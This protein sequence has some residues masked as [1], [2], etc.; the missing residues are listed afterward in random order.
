MLWA[1]QLTCIPWDL[2]GR[3]ETCS[4]KVWVAE[5]TSRHWR[6]RGGHWYMIQG[7]PGYLLCTCV[8][9]LRAMLWSEAEWPSMSER[10]EGLLAYD[11]QG[12]GGV[13]GD[14]RA[15]NAGLERVVAVW[16]AMEVGTGV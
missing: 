6:L 14:R 7:R 1:Q 4:R 5:E 8:D 12:R 16:P 11:L 9:M 2:V 15:G 13:V 10:E 3:L